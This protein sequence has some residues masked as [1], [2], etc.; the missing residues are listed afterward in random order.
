MHIQVFTPKDYIG[1]I[2]ELVVARRG[3]FDKMEYLD[4]VRVMLSYLSRSRN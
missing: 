4:E 2:M 1:P 3:T